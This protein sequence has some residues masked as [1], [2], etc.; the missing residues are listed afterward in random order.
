M[1]TT[2]R[3]ELKRS[4]QGDKGDQSPK[5]TERPEMESKEDP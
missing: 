1:K 4:R 5:G 2:G 3:E